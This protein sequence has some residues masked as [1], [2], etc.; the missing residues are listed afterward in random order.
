MKKLIIENLYQTEIT[1][2]GKYKSFEELSQ[3]RITK[4]VRQKLRNKYGKENITVSCAASFENGLWKGTCII[5][6][7]EY[8]YKI[9]KI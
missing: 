1:G 2:L 9:I 8:K 5:N 4:S 6:G 3:K 7:N